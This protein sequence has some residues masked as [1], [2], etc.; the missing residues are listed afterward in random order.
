MSNKQTLEFT[1]PEWLMADGLPSDLLTNIAGAE[2]GFN[3]R[4][5]VIVAADGTDL[6]DFWDEVQQT[7]AIR[8][9]RRN[10]LLNAFTTRVT[11]PID[12][13]AVPSS[14]QFEEASEYGQPVGMR[15]GATRYFRGYDFRF[16]DLAIRYTWMF[17]AEADAAQLRMNHNL[18]LDADTKMQFNKVMKC[19]FN[20]L[21]TVGVGDKNEPVTVYKFYNA[22]GEV[23]PQYGNSAFDGTHNHYLVSGNSALTS[24]NVDTLANDFA[25][26]GYTLQNQYKLVL[27]VNTQEANLIRAF[28]TSTGAK[29]DFVP[30]PELYGGKI[31]VP[32]NGQ[33]VGGPQGVVA[34]EIGTYGPFH[35]VEEALIPAGY[36][37]AL[38]TGGTESLNNP[39]GFREH[40]NP[41]YRGLK[42]IPGQRSDYPLLD[43]FYRR[44]FGTGIR[45]RGG[46]LLMQVTTNPT[47]TI[48]AAYV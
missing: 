16:Y 5:D 13:V 25:A 22:D 37:V 17:I 38:A 44:G 28:K 20:S 24:A 39:I 8:N 43:S 34:G 14:V 10:A 9:V 3:E 40:T 45:Q 47:Y 19:L 46:G 11:A 29:F 1:L 41:A 35:I 21:N 26:H 6:N 12:Q 27:W 36:V 23:P 32:N 33:Y 30:N 48:P 31:W 2:Q 42:I 18:A 7:I 4:A 15:G